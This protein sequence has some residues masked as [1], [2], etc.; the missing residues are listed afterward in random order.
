VT[1][2]KIGKFGIGEEQWSLPPGEINRQAIAPLRGYVYQIHQT[3]SAWIGL[4]GEDQ[5]YLEVAEDFAL[6]AKEP[7]RLDE[8]L[9]ATQVKDTRESGSVTLNSADV[10]DAISHLFEL[11]EANPD[12]GVRL[13]FLTTSP[14]G[15]ERKNPLASGRPGIT[16][17]HS[18]SC[19]DD[20]SELRT[21]LCE[22]YESGQL[23]AFLRTSSNDELR[24]RILN[25][26]NFVC[27][28]GDW[29]EVEAANR[30]ALVAARGEVSASL[31]L[32][33]RAYDVLFSEALR[34]IFSD[35]RMLNRQKFLGCFSKA[36]T[37]GLP[38]QTLVDLLSQV[39]LKPVVAV[40]VDEDRLHGLAEAL[41]KVNAPPS[42]L[43]LFGDA[44]EPARNALVS[45]F[46]VER[47]IAKEHKSNGGQEASI[48]L[49]ELRRRSTGHQLL[50]GP[51]G[52]GKTQSLWQAATAMLG[53][54]ETI[55]LLLSV[56]DFKSWNEVVESIVDLGKGIDATAV[57]RHDKVCVC[58][59]GWSE[60]TGIENVVER[61]KAIRALQGIQ[62]IANGRQ[63]SPSDTTFESWRLEPL[64]P[65][66]VRETLK[67]AFGR[68]P[69]PDQKLFDLLRSPL[70]LSLY[71]LL[72]GSA[73]SP[74]ELLE[75]LHRHLS[76]GIPE[77]FDN[78]LSGAVAS[79]VLSSGRSY[80]GLLA[81]LRDRAKALNLDEPTKLLERLGT[82][83][84]RGGN[85][86]PI[87]DLYWSWLSGLG[88]LHENRIEQALLRLDTREGYD[89]AIQSKA[90][91]TANL[92]NAT[93]PRDVVLAA[94]FSGSL[95]GQDGEDRL[96]S[97]LK[98]MFANP[99]LSVRCRA[100]LAGFR[101]RKSRYLSRSLDIVSD[102]ITAKLF[103]LEFLDV[104]KPAE[105]F[106]N[107]GILGEWLGS[108]GT[109]LLTD[110]I[111][112]EGGPEWGPWLEQVTRSGKLSP[113]LAL[114]AA[115]GCSGDVP[116]WCYDHLEE[117]IRSEPWKLRPAAER[118]ANLSLASWIA[119]RYGEM[120]DRW[121]SLG[122]SGGFELNRVLV[123]CGNDSIF[124][125][126]LVNFPMMPRK[127]QELL[128]YAV[129]ERGDSWIARFQRLAFTSNDGKHH[130]RL[131]EQVSLDIDDDTARR[132]ISLGHDQLGW[133]VLITRYGN[134]IVPEL[135]ANLP[136]SFDGLHHVPSL[137]AM[138]F[139]TDAPASLP[140]EIWSRI[141][142][143]MQP[144]AM[145]DALEAVAKVVPSGVPSIVRF[146]VDQPG[147]LP[148]YH[149]AQVVRLYSEWQKRFSIDLRVRAPEGDVSFREWALT[150][151]LRRTRDKDFLLRGFEYA[152]ELA[153]RLV[154]TDL[155]SDD[156]MAKS[157]LGAI[158]P[159]PRYEPV[160]FERM[161]ASALLAPMIPHLFS[162]VVDMVPVE[163]LRQIIA[164]PYVKFEDL[165]WRLSKTSNPLHK[166][167][168]VELI[169][170]VL[171]DP[172]NLH[173]YRY[174]GQMLRSYPRDE[175]REM[176]RPVVAHGR[177]QA[178]W[179]LREI[180]S[181]RRERLVDEAGQLL[182]R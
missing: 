5:L 68:L 170:R 115:L 26:L 69:P 56:G 48:T 133:R 123:S 89:L 108:S 149:M 103:P 120:V 119:A 3:L 171:N 31:D 39:S 20:I 132:W 100:A 47:T 65:G 163:N 134:A 122:G 121:I 57:L 30:A 168:H 155:A 136:Q 150:T 114:G 64:A 40:P 152:S 142:G 124:D 145:Q 77:R 21:T 74:G 6:I 97:Q 139:L 157:I 169:A 160:L 27:G 137:A 29:K 18:I 19:A 36:T 154:L 106:P 88:F 23:G 52:S 44:P 130:H 79:M 66:V 2:N 113:N 91:A 32:V 1:D 116:A 17:W 135:I 101:S 125:T 80:A 167:L 174:I 43:A 175:V 158:K 85:A 49:R 146:C 15:M 104:F 71:V 112:N 7:E 34:T 50:V 55:P 117:L 151:M 99:D 33:A 172:M 165:L 111:A 14:I 90:K 179:M 95:E 38:S 128:G 62:V 98:E 144:K 87:H 176:I 126:L 10:L 70:V 147:A 110:A 76:R 41:L 35:D 42:M 164:S 61:T 84:E 129:V 156:N 58:L 159:L 24:E 16:A 37:I 127:A 8:V 53:E 118:G 131:A 94:E 140:N 107:R 63:T 92:A 9:R 161:I 75:R 148:S 45:L 11:Q 82:I 81:E 173:H 96:E 28:A 177:E 60:F 51:P 46:R 141:R 102:V 93:A 138:S 22:R 59:D 105:L 182:D 153:V 78:A 54:R 143:T 181:A 73:V 4:R 25:R 166:P 67:S 72:G 178:H 83:T 12:R 109:S 86:L 13:T 162:D 180:E